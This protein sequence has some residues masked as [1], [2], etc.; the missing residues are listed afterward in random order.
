MKSISQ[1]FLSFFLAVFKI[2][3]V[4]KKL[5]QARLRGQHQYN[6]DQVRPKLRYHTHKIV[7]RV[8]RLIINFILNKMEIKQI[9]TQLKLII[10]QIYS[11]DYSITNL[12]SIN[13][14]FELFMNKF[15]GFQIFSVTQ[16]VCQSNLTIKS[17]AY[18]IYSFL[19]AVKKDPD[20]RLNLKKIILLIFRH[21]PRF[22]HF[23]GF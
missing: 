3:K 23:C 10:N 13:G 1:V 15:Y 21:L 6:I 17:V 16:Y 20:S 22:L 2:N 11:S 18:P 19:A 7:S 9:M 8:W 5:K 12:S 14:L 4:S